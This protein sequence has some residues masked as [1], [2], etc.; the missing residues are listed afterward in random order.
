MEAVTTLEKCGIP[1]EQLTAEKAEIYEQL[2]QVN[3]EIRAER[4]HLALCQEI[5]DRLPKME[6]S[7]QR[8]EEKDEVKRNEY[9]RR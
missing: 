8:I 9:R 1:K 5:Q 2:A 4:K 6:R 3:R 7:L